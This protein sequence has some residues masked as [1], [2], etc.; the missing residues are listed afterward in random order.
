MTRASAVLLLGLAAGCGAPEPEP[1][2]R[3]LSV[4]PQ[5]SGVS[6]GAAAE[7]RF[8]DPADPAGLV[9][10]SRAVLVPASA[11]AEALEAVESEAG[12]SGLAA[13]IDVAPSLLDGGRRL[14]LVP[15]APLRAFT[16]HAVVLSSR[17]RA[18]DGRPILDPD[19]RRRPVVAR[20]ETGAR[21]GPQPL[22]V[23][24]E[25]RSDAATPEAGG[26]YVE[27]ANLGDG[28]LDLEGWKLSKR[29]LSGA[30][31]SCTISLA[32]PVPPGV[33]ALV[34][35]GAWDGRYALAAGTPI[36]RCGATAVL[37]GLANDRAPDL[38]LSTPLGN[39]ISTFG[40]SGGPVCAEAA[41][42][43][44]PRGPDDPA[45]LECTAGSPGTIAPFVP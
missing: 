27:V 12:A 7:I 16:A 4:S 32:A 13:A 33:V 44:D 41:E 15:R 37:G 10:G 25:V 40:A 28:A 18:A 24:T 5:G 34:A 9:D 1:L 6:P 23:L 30:L 2:P 20:F 39:V 8:S 38:R 45:N 31:A 17:A 29:T 3:V 35:G 11:S 14:A 26:E 42:R 43:V 19:G 22:P 36:A 21:E